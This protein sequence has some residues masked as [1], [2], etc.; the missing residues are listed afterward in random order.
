MLKIRFVVTRVPS[1]TGRADQITTFKAV[2]YLRSVGCDVC[3][4]VL[5]RID[6]SL[7]NLF[8]V[9][10]RV[11]VYKVP[12]Q[13]AIYESTQNRKLLDDVFGDSSADRV[14]LHLSRSCIY[15][16]T[17]P[18]NKVFVGLQ[19]S[20]KLNFSRTANEL[21]FGPKKIAFWVESI[22]SGQFERKVIAKSRAVNFVGTADVKVTG[23]RDINRK[24]SVIPHG[25]DFLPLNELFAKGKK[26]ERK[27]IIFL[28][29]FGSQ[30]NKSALRYLINLVWPRLR[31]RL[32]N[33]VRLKI[34]GRNIPRWVNQSR[35]AGVVVGG[36]VPSAAYEISKHKLFLN[37][38][39]ASAGMQNKVLVALGAGVP[40]VSTASAVEGMDLSSEGLF[41]CGNDI[42]S[43]V[44]TAEL[45]YTKE[46]PPGAAMALAESTRSKWTWDALHERWASEFLKIDVKD[47]A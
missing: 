38:V 37:P 18:E 16:E 2:E 14:Y 21:R 33:V 26:S 6:F 39:R 19:V 40:V 34:A 24:I 10:W 45:V 13:V 36:E 3:V 31:V 29:N 5:N 12:G 7:V 30:A 23:N 47:E 42:D 28:A 20:Q 9:L 22:L 4:D 41:T 27:D 15:L 35:I 32:P 46:L 11:A 1:P 17:L 43:F 25:V 8:R 44:R